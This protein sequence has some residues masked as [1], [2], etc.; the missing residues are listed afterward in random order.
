MASIHPFRALRP[1]P[2]DAAAVSSVPY[3]VVSTEE[4]RELAA[5]NPLSFLHVTRPEIDLPPDTD[6]YSA[7]VYQKGR[8]NLE[9]L[10]RDGAADG[11]DDAGAVSLPA[12]HGRA[13]ADRCCRLFLRR[14]VRAG[15]HQEARTDAARQGRRSHAPHDRAAGADRRRVPDLQGRRQ[16]STRWRERITAAAPLF[17]FTAADGVHHTIWAAS[18]DEHAA[19]R[20]SVRAGAGPLHRR[21]PSSR[22]ERGARARRAAAARRRRREADTFIAVAF[23]DNQMQILPYHRTVRISP[24]A[25]RQQFLAELRQQFRVTDGPGAA[26]AQGRGRDVS[27]RPVVHARPVGGAAARTTRAPARSTSRCCSITCSRSC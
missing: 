15:R 11:R 1:M 14:R 4:A 8:E 16:R 24:A 12:A 26:A 17:D 10:R 5:G 20:R 9:Q 27:R 7:A 25:R 21:R 3:D 13:R 19:D 2:A 22:R 23:P 6:P 18:A